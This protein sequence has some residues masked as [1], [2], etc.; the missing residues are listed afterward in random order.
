MST[1]KIKRGL[2]ANRS[3]ITP[4]EGEL[5]YT[6]DE[7]KIYVGDGTTL[8]GSAIGSDGSSVDNIGSRNTTLNQDAVSQGTSTRTGMESLLGTAAT[9]VDTTTSDFGGLIW[10]KDRVNATSHVLS[11]SV[12]GDFYLKSDT[13]ATQVATVPAQATQAEIDR[14]IIRDADAIVQTDVDLSADTSTIRS[15][16][17]TAD[18][19]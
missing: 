10:S 14:Q 19:L 5:L 6:T 3:S 16:L 9:S 11:D 7:K 18:Y 4:L 15:V 8:G 12:M 2:E 1:I 13:T 17:S